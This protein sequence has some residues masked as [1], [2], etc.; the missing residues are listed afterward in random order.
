MHSLVNF[1]HAVNFF[2]RP[3]HEIR[4]D[5]L[6]TVLSLNV[7]LGLRKKIML[8]NWC[9][10]VIMPLLLNSV[11]F[12]RALLCMNNMLHTDSLLK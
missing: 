2:S 6:M 12:Y 5:V 10:D 8:K 3:F 11:C 4:T 7:K 9:T 1:S